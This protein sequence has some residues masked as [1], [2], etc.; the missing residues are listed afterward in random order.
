MALEIAFRD[1]GLRL[2][3]LSEALHE[4]R[5]IVQDKPPGE[6][7]MLVDVLAD[8]VDSI[9]GWLEEAAIAAANARQAVGHPVDLDRARRELT[10]CQESVS[11]AERQFSSELRS[12]ERIAELKRLAAPPGGKWR[13]WA[14]TVLNAI[15]ACQPP[16]YEAKLALVAGWQALAERVGMP[17]IAVQAT[18]I[19]QQI[20]VKEP[21]REAIT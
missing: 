2:K 12:Y 4:L 10:S 7:V 14:S 3:D 5:I 8:A 17:T 11:L 1:L 13:R 6:D 19:G 16:L 9:S 18:N 21:L 20:E 15:D